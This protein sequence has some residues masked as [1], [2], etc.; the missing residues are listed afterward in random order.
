MAFG[1]QEAARAAELYRNVKRPRKR[2]VDLAIAACA[3]CAD[4]VLWTL[5]VEDFADVPGL[6]VRR[7]EG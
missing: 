3:L 1:A 7:P 5:N 2:E 6:R 4:A